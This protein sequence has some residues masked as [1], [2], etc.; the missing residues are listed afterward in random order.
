MPVKLPFKPVSTEETKGEAFSVANNRG[1]GTHHSR[2]ID[3]PI[4]AIDSEGYTDPKDK[5]HKLDLVAAAG[6]NWTDYK[7]TQSDKL[8]PYEIFDFLLSLP[9]KHGKAL[10]FIYSGSYDATMWIKQLP[11]WAIKK[12]RK[13]GIV[14][15]KHYL[16]KYVQRR[17][18]ILYDKLSLQMKLITRGKHAGEYR[19]WYSRQIHIYDVFGFFQMSFVKALTRW[20]IADQTTI[21]RIASMKGQRGNFSEVEKAKILAYCLEECSLLVELGDAFRKACIEADIKPHHWYGAGALASTLMRQYRIKDHISEDPKATPYIKRSY[22]GGRTEISYQGRL[23]HG[24]YQ[25]DINSAYPTAMVDLPSLASGSWKTTLNSATDFANYQYS[26]W[27]VRWNCHGKLW[28]PFPW[29]HKDGRIFYPDTGEGFYHK[30]EIDAALKLY[31]DCDFEIM[32]GVAFVPDNDYKPFAFIVERAAYRLKLKMDGAPAEKPLKLGLNSL[33]GKTAQTI[34]EAPPYQ[35]FFWAGLIT[36]TTRAKL[37]DAIRYCNGYIYSVATDG[38]ISSVEIDELSVG[39]NLGQW[40]KTKIVEGLLI[41]PGV[42][43]WL[44]SKGEYHYGTRGFQPDELLWNTIENHWDTGHIEVPIQY[45]VTRFIGITQALA[46]GDNWRD[47]LGEWIEQTRSLSFMPTW[48]TRF[49]DAPI[50]SNAYPFPIING[51]FVRLKLECNCHLQFF[52][53]AS[54]MYSR[55][56]QEDTEEGRTLLIDEDQP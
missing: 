10:Y 28:G 39:V 33:Y 29:R 41:R 43:K 56:N 48:S 34:G 42:Y 47:Y 5:K 8:T 12:W 9:E 11:D 15:W 38:L 27:H 25:Y 32:D 30:I 37:L 44:D 31:P 18:F 49:W 35:C 3:L 46:R 52:D 19:K 1:T 50:A 4:V 51:G 54:A 14:S 6:S 21:D 20:K 23:P 22:F 36:A 13:K 16:F 17:E 55:L 53:G 7:D 45:V 40:D 24:G 2:A 26:I